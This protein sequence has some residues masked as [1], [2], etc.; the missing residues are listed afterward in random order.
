V[1]GI[2]GRNSDTSGWCP[3]YPTSYW[4]NT[5]NKNDYFPDGSFTDWA[6]AWDYN[7][8]YVYTDLVNAQCPTLEDMLSR[9]TTYD[10]FS[11]MMH[12]L[13]LA[14]QAGCALADEVLAKLVEPW[15]AGLRQ[16]G[17][18]ELKYCASPA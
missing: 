2:A 16:Y 13:R 15:E 17:Y 12:A 9:N 1:Q 4:T 14:S 18:T 7:S 8:Q 3:G 11:A 6:A 10:Y 5:T